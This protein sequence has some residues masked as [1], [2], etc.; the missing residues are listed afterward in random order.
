MVSAFLAIS[1]YFDCIAGMGLFKG[2]GLQIREPYTPKSPGLSRFDNLQLFCFVLIWL[3][4]RMF[5]FNL[6]THLIGCRFFI[7][8]KVK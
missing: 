6:T 4:I 8:A 1:A 7:F 3:L 5:A 2:G